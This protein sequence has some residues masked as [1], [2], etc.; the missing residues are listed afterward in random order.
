[1]VLSLCASLESYFALRWS[2]GSLRCF[3]YACF[4]AQRLHRLCRSPTSHLSVLSCYPQ[5]ISRRFDVVPKESPPTSTIVFCQALTTETDD[6]QVLRLPTDCCVGATFKFQGW[7]G[8]ATNY[9]KVRMN[10]RNEE[11]SAELFS[12]WILTI[13]RAVYCTVDYVSHS[14]RIRKIFFSPPPSYS[15]SSRLLTTPHCSLARRPTRL[16]LPRRGA[17]HHCE[18][19]A[20]LLRR[21]YSVHLLDGTNCLNALSCKGFR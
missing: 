7:D 13:N 12:L 2:V 11:L 14:L 5:V 1:M 3:R 4:F 21:R 19:I 17:D 8:F 20:A 10:L 9:P 6:N 18:L 15:S 16:L